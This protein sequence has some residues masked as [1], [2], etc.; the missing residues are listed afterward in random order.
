[1]FFCSLALRLR[2]LSRGFQRLFPKI[3]RFAVLPHIVRIRAFV[4]Q[5]ADEAAYGFQNTPRKVRSFSRKPPY[6]G[7]IRHQIPRKVRR[8][9]LNGFLPR[10]LLPRILRKLWI[11]SAFRI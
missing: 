7:F 11:C 1:M 8:D 2:A 6:I 5:S 3:F 4:G 9:L 10:E